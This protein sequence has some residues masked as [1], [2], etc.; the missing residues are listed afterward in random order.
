MEIA[1]PTQVVF[2]SNAQF[3]ERD[4]PSDLT[5][6]LWATIALIGLAIMSVAFGVATEVDAAIFAA[7]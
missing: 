3:G 5:F 2:Y 1:M 4:N 7:P 6:G